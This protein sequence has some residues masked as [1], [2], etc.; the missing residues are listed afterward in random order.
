MPSSPQNEDTE[1][2]QRN[3]NQQHITKNAASRKFNLC[4]IGLINV[5]ELTIKAA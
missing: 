5:L 4:A 2:S 1:D 3:T